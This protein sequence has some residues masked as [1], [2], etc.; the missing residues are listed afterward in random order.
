M[1]RSAEEWARSRSCHRATFSRPTAALRAGCERDRR[2]ARR[3]SGCACAASPRSPSGR[4]RTAP[5]PRAPRC[6]AGG[7]SRVAKRSSDGATIAIAESSAAWRS[8][9]TTCVGTGIAP[10]PSALA[11]QRLDARV[12]AARRPRRRRRACRPRRRRR[13]RPPLARPRRA[14]QPAEQLQPERGRLGVHAVGAADH[15]RVAGC[16]ARRRTA[17]ERA[18]TVPGRSAAGV[19]QLQRQ[20]RVD[21]VGGRE[22][23]VEPARAGT[24]LLGDGLG[25]GQDV[26]V[27]ARARSPGCALD[28]DAARSP[29]SPQGRIWDDPELAPRRRGRRS[30]RRARPLELALVRPDGAD[31]GRV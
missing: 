4:R 24:D 19:A 17:L 30:R 12:D 8:R 6:A 15:R 10:M 29:G 1:T 5:G 26:V 31:P 21:H 14:R 20:R 27:G 28:V 13:R 16:S 9:D 22:A 2:C 25:E 18:S 23:V 3:R 7:G 11:D